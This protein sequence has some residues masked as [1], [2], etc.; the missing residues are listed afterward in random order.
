LNDSDAA[1]G[2]VEHRFVNHEPK[3]HQ[4]AGGF[5]GLKCCATWV[6]LVTA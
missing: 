2:I 1:L 6:H 3:P 5:G 4:P